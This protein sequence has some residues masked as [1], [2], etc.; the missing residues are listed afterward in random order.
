MQNPTSQH[1]PRAV[2]A[3]SAGGQPLARSLTSGRLLARNAIWNGLGYLLPLLV[4]VPAIPVLVHA[5]GTD[6]FGVLALAWIVLGYLTFFDLGLGRALT[7]LLARRIALHDE[8][9]LSSLTWTAIGLMTAI[10]LAVMGAVLLLSPRLVHT[11]LRVPPAIQS[12]TVG[13]F[14]LLALSMPVIVSAIGLRSVLEANQRFFLINAVRLPM[15]VFVFLG[16]VA[17][18]PF[19]SDLRLL[20]LALV[21]GRIGAWI[22]QLVMA[23]HV[24]PSLRRGLQFQV[25]AVMPLIRFGSW[26]TVT[27]I[28]SPFMVYLDRFLIGSVISVAGIAY[29][30]TPYEMVTKLSLVAGALSGVL[31]PAFAATFAQ[32]SI[33][34]RLL[35]ARGVK[36]V[37]LALLPIVFVIVV[38]AREVIRLWL[39]ANFASHSAQVMQL[40]AIGV[41]FNALAQMP[42]TLVQGVGRPDLTARLH[43]AELP[44]YCAAL[45]LAISAWGLVGAAAAASLRLTIDCLVLFFLARKF[46]SLGDVAK[47]TV[48]AGLALGLIAVP[49]LLLQ[50]SGLKLVLTSVS[51]LG[52]LL[53]TWFVLLSDQERN[54]LREFRRARIPARPPN[55][56]KVD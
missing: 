41:L 55:G 35:F 52:Y 54:L 47:P 53:G 40:L 46:V 32:D 26:T 17:V 27:N 5:L 38:L 8:R 15:G 33:R 23:I 42:F 22:A 14:Y 48:L 12:E 34:T 44:F 4:A 10:S 39:G 43:L 56:V 30:A 31:F 19:S 7:Q 3:R 37:F 9:E 16:P 18:L 20:V 29:Y 25:D 6:R 50:P 49:L 36:F 1:L 2:T 13:A 21:V 11:V 45:W 24:M 28:V 51:L